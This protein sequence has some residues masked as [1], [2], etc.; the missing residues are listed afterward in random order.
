MLK[1]G[2]G[3][4]R[5]ERMAEK[6]EKDDVPIRTAETLHIPFGGD[7]YTPESDALSLGFDPNYYP[8]SLVSG[9]VNVLESGEYTVTYGITDPV[10]NKAFRVIRPV[11]VEEKPEPETGLE[12]VSGLKEAAESDTTENVRPIRNKH[13]RRPGRAYRGDAGRNGGNDG[14]T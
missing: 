7:G 11:V 14:S 12:G 6:A 13:L 9:D 3:T 8:V 2:P 10:I 5:M 1:D 4:Y